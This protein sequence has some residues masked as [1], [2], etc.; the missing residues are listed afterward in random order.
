MSISNYS[1]QYGQDSFVFNEVFK[2]KQNEGFFVDIG[3]HDGVTLS[4]TLFL[5]KLGWKGVCVEPIPRLFQKLKENRGCLCVEGCVSN[6]DTD[7]VEFCDISGY[8]EMLSGIEQCYDQNHVARINRELQET[9]GSV[10]RIKVKNYK[11]NDIILEKTIHYLSLDTEG[12]EL[13][14]LKSIDWN[15][16]LILSMSVENNSCT[17]EIQSF[18]TNQCMS[19]VERLGC[20]EMYVNRNFLCS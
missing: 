11:F 8:S 12:S 19:L 13:D 10:E 6:L 14:I 3:A 9:G 4:N 18:L 15:K 1:S 2:S 17:S 5:E 20:D 16:Y 7:I